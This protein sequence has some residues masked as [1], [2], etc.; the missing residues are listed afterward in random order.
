MGVKPGV[1]DIFVDIPKPE[2]NYRGLWIELKVGARKPTEAQ[3]LFLARKAVQ[4]Y[5]TV[6]VVGFDAAVAFIEGYLS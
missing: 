5:C 1:S 4:G 6:C 3:K 2:K